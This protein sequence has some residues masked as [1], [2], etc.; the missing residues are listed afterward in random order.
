MCG[1]IGDGNDSTV[2]LL[3]Y[4]EIEPSATFAQTPFDGFD[5][6]LCGDRLPHNA[7]E[8]IRVEIRRLGTADNHDRDVPRLRVRLQ[9]RVDIKSAEARKA[10]IQNDQ[11]GGVG[12]NSTQRVDTVVRRH[13]VVAR[14]SQDA[15]IKGQQRGIV[16]DH[17]D[18]RFGWRG[19]H[20]A[21]LWKSAPSLQLKWQPPPPAAEFMDLQQHMNTCV[22]FFKSSFI[23]TPEKSRHFACNA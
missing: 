8:V 6:L 19:G 23:N 18:G 22:A 15:Q 12:L 1:W 9:F 14:D 13:D 3:L 5:Q 20:R 17:Q 16:L 7:R 2:T 21:S 10:Q 11:G 4:T